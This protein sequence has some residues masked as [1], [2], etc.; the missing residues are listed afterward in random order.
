[1]PS[2]EIHSDVVLMAVRASST[3]AGGDRTIHRWLHG[4]GRHGSVARSRAT[5]P[6]RTASPA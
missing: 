3:S 6:V 2:T 1:M 5:A 4:T